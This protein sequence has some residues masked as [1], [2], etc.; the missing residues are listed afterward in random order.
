MFTI[1]YR[2]KHELKLRTEYGMNSDATYYTMKR[3]YDVSTMKSGHIERSGDCQ[4][5]VRLVD[6]VSMD[7]NTS[8]DSHRGITE[9]K[10]LVLQQVNVMDGNT[11]DRNFM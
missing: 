3:G 5:L 8:P 4:T 7:T 10:P 11:S 6:K 9:I 1:F 2:I